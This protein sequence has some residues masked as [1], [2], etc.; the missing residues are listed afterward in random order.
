MLFNSLPFLLFFAVVYAVYRRLPHRG[1][2]AWLLASSWFF[3]GWWDWRFLSLIAASTAVDF[4]CGKRVAADR[5]RG[6]RWVLLSVLVNLGILATFKYYGWFADEVTAFFDVVDVP[7][8]LPAVDLVLPVGLSFYTFQSM[9]YTID[10]WRGRDPCERPLDFA[11]FV[12]FFPQLVAGPIERSE[13][14]LPQITEPRTLKREQ[15]AEGMHLLVWGFFK[16]VFVADNLAVIVD[17]AYAGGQPGGLTV[18]LAAYA[19]TWQ[20][21]CDFSGYSSIA[22]GLAKL[23]GVEL[24]VNFRLPLFADSPRDLWR[25]WHISLSQWLRDYLYIPLGGSR[26]GRVGLNLIATMVLGGLW[27]GANWTFVIWGLLHGLALAAHRAL[28]GRVPVPRWLAVVAT[29]HLTVLGFLIFRAADVGQ[30]AALLSALPWMA[31]G[32]EDLRAAARLLVLV[33]PVLVIELAMWLR[34]SDLGLLMKLPRAA[35]AVLIAVMVALTLMLGATSGQAFL[36][37]Q[38]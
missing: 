28:A 37:F 25:R 35:Q 15:L 4:V 26:S 18:L 19:F 9:A 5:A 8:Y 6:G 13:R 2:N 34:G 38:F 17:R 20:I 21:Y 27:H 1:Q 10:V 7:L 22:R 33:A 11:L 3:Y 30:A 36:Y 24:S 29:F 31:A 14:L 23:L 16:K 12:S 32:G